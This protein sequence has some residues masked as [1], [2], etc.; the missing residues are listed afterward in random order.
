MKLPMTAA[1][2]AALALAACTS[3]P[4]PSRGERV[5]IA[6]RALGRARV[7]AEPGKVV[8]ADIALARAALDEGQWTAFRR[9]AAPGAQLDEGR[10]P[11]D[12]ATVL[13]TRA[14]P[15]QPLRWAVREVWSSCDGTLAASFGRW[16]DAGIVG[17]YLTIWQRQGD[18]SYRWLY[19]SGSTDNPQP[20][21]H[22]PRWHPIPTPSS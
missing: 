17:N 20:R 22:P 12:A 6:E 10:G 14:D 9:F 1:L 5:R 19:R 13:S 8:A 11:A 3:S 18:G 2:V 4:G 7:I 15:P 16:R 21:P